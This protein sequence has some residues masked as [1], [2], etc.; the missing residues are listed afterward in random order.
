MNRIPVSSSNLRSVGYDEQTH[1][2][3]V[4]FTHGGIYQYSGVPAS[5]YRNLM[6]AGSKGSFFD[7]YIRK[8]NFPYRQIG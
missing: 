6:S 4:Q 8:G 7:R 1:T 5:I 2:L 3:E